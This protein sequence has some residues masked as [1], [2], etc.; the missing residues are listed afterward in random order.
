MSSLTPGRLLRIGGAA[1][2]IVALG[3]ALAPL[4]SVVM[5]RVEV[6][7]VFAQVAFILFYAVAEVAFV[8]GSLLTLAAGAVFGVGLGTLVALTGATLGAAAG[9][10]ATI[11]LTGVQTRAARRA[12]SAATA[13]PSV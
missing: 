13:E 2:A 9:L 7:G 12:L 8:P 4:V 6:L 10:V 5:A 3:R 1:L 11:V